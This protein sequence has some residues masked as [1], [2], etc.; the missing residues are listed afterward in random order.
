VLV[1]SLSSGS[2][3]VLS[4]AWVEE[5]VECMRICAPLLGGLAARGPWC[6][7]LYWAR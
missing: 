4:T 5:L 2:L 7:A 3:C 1:D 6:G